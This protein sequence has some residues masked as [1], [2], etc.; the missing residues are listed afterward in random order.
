MKKEA[1]TVLCLWLA[2]A[3]CHT[4]ADVR[5]K[6]THVF[7]SCWI[8]FSLETRRA[9]LTSSSLPYNAQHSAQH[10]II[11]VPA[12]INYRM[13]FEKKV[14]VAK[15]CAIERCIF[16]S[17]KELGQNF[18]VIRL[19]NGLLKAG[20]LGPRCWLSDAQKWWPSKRAEWSDLWLFV[21]GYSVALVV[22]DSMPPHRPWDWGV[23]KNCEYFF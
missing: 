6:Y 19:A 10:S 22:S 12:E 18:E 1:R 11:K 5:V 23:F 4:R 8:P 21:C 15:D 9:Q 16:Q 7:Y 20:L 3:V 17:I 2:Y 13:F 14:Q